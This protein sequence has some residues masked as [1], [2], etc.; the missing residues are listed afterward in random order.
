MTTTNTKKP[1]SRR[2]LLL[3]LMW[4]FAI[5]LLIAGA[6]LANH[7]SEARAVCQIGLVAALAEGLQRSQRVVLRGRHL[8]LRAA[9]RAGHQSLAL[10][11]PAGPDL[12]GRCVVKRASIPAAL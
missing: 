8:A 3:I 9:V 6:G 10:P 7:L 2:T 4:L 11:R 5:V 1:V 12:G